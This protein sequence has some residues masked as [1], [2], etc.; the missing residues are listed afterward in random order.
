M[1][2]M[3][4]AFILIGSC[5]ETGVSL[6]MIA[7][8]ARSASVIGVSESTLRSGRPLKSLTVPPTRTMAPALR[9][10]RTG[11]TGESPKTRILMSSVASAMTAS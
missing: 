3:S 8:S 4:S 10:V 1:M 5:C 9:L 6:P 2:A 11:F 7:G